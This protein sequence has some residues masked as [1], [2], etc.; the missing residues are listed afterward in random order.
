MIKP[1]KKNSWKNF[2]TLII[3]SKPPKF[4][5]I[6]AFLLSI[7]STFLSLLMPLMI[8]Y[9]IDNFESITFT[10]STLLLIVSF[11]IVQGMLG[12]VSLYLLTYIGQKVVANFRSQLWKK[13]LKLPLQ[14]YNNNKTGELV[15]R[16]VNDTLVIKG[17][18]T[19]HLVD[20]VTGVIITLGS[21]IILF[22]LNWEMTV[23]V[24]LSIIISFFLIL[25]LSK[26]MYNI[27]IG[28]QNELAKFSATIMQGLSMIQLIK[29]SNMELEEY[30]RGSKDVAELFKFSIKEGK[31]IAIISPIL[32]F[33]HILSISMVIIYGSL[34]V[35]T[36][37]LSAGE[38]VAFVLYLFQMMGPMSQFTIFFNQLQKAKG[39]T[40][41]ISNLLGEQEELYMSVQELKN[42]NEKITYE[43]VYFEYNSNEQILK[44]ITFDIDPGKVTAIVGPSGSG[45]TTI[46]SLL[47][48]FYEPI[49][50]AIKI[51]KKNINTYSINSWRDNIG[52][53]SQDTT[54]FAGTIKENIAYGVKRDVTDEDIAKAAK[55]AYADEFIE[56][57]TDKYNTYVGERGVKL[58]GGQRQ[59][60][61]IAR[62][63]LRNPQLLM[64]DEATSSLD[65][66]SEAIVQ[67]ALNNLMVGRTTL[68]ITHRLSTIKHADKI[69]LI[70]NGRIIGSGTHDELIENHAMYREFAT[71]QLLIEH[72]V[73]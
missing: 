55:L 65:S 4:L 43:N 10:S 6:V 48:R 32:S 50:G 34:Q 58:S 35:S 61:G 62:V 9:L 73:I 28:Y 36:G 41:N 71:N 40:E 24:L 26:K 67:K 66:T 64:L 5:I 70:D 3:N 19:N 14:F 27:T 44:N 49:K 53:V 29:S 21:T 46:F 60:I 2:F 56:K 8:K 72:S 57:M 1:S 11:F 33:L 69:I 22:I 37:S 16:I 12:G 52:Y 7:I 38:L 42:I 13:Y 23:I 18:V 17:I 15:S 63:L 59:R 68:I 31:L 51:G 45:K 39:A 47:E 25:P 20:F 54:I 30:K